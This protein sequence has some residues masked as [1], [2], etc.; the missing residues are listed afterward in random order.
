MQAVK[1]KRTPVMVGIDPRWELLPKEFH[2]RYP[3]PVPLAQVASSYLTFVQGVIDAVADLVGVVKFQ[4]AFFEAAGMSGTAALDYGLRYANS[5]ELVVVLDGKRG[6]IGTTADAYADAYLDATRGDERAWMADALTVNPFLGRETIEPFVRVARQ[7]GNGIFMLVRTS[8][9]GSG[10][11]QQI[12]VDG[13]T[14]SERLASWAEEWSLQTAGELGYGDVGAVVGATH[15]EEIAGFRER[16]K[17]SPILL[18]GYGAQGATA[19]DI[20]AAFDENGFGAVV[21]NSR[22]I[23]FAHRN[24]KFSS[25][26]WKE[27]IRAA[28][29]EM[30]ADLAANTPAGNLR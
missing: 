23:I 24:E 8:N 9:P 29:E 19:S 1:A 21:N 14:V 26:G 22:G 13:M 2:D 10:D 28:T 7:S 11:L 5:K 17:H 18:P 4:A 30:I 25:L 12:Q 6:D 15:R 3:Q 27:A 20:A 16:L